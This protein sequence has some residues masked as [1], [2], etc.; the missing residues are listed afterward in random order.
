VNTALSIQAHPDKLLAE[1]L[2]KND[3]KNYKDD[4]YKPEMSIALTDFEML[5]KFV[6][7]ST[8]KR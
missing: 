6:D 5:Y 4:N 8:L 3:P 7:F 2:F 1:K